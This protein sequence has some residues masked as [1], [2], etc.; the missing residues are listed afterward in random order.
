V[1]HDVIECGVA[2]YLNEDCPHGA[3]M[4]AC[5]LANHLPHL[6]Q[7]AAQRAGLGSD[8][9]LADAF[10]DAANTSSAFVG[11]LRYTVAL[12]ARA[13]AATASTVNPS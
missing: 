4:R 7:I 11:H 13:V 6:Q 3:G 9:D 5:M 2:R 8:S 10:D 1:L 12:L